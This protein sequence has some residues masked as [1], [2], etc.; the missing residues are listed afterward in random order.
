MADSTNVKAAKQAASAPKPQHD[1]LALAAV[2]ISSRFP[3]FLQSLVIRLL[4]SG[5]A[6]PQDFSGKMPCFNDPKPKGTRRRGRHRKGIRPFPTS[7]PEGS[8]ITW[9]NMYDVRTEKILDGVAVYLA[10]TNI[11][12]ADLEDVVLEIREELPFC[13][14]KFSPAPGKPDARYNFTANAAYNL[15]KSKIGQRR[16]E[17]RDGLPTISLEESLDDDG[18]LAIID[19]IPCENNELRVAES[20]EMLRLVFPLLDERDQAIVFMSAYLDLS[21]AQ[22]GERLGKKRGSIHYRLTKVIPRIAKK[23]AARTLGEME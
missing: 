20:L 1:A 9:A 10:K 15:A 12:G 2:D 13:L 3:D 22:I 8:G 7:F 11:F 14:Q 23:I 17:I 16:R 6:Y 5:K 18:E 19:T 4:E 21:V